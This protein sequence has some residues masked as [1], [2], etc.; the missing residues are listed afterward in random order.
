LGE[1]FVVGVKVVGCDNA[2][3]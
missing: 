1:Y 2:F 3:D